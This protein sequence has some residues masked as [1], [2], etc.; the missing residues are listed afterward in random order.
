[1]KHIV[2]LAMSLL[3][4]IGLLITP[5]LSYA[6]NSSDQLKTLEDLEDTYNVKLQIDPNYDGAITTDALAITSSVRLHG[7]IPSPKSFSVSV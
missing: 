3:L 7:L 6:S 5:A 2:K 4:L 1:M